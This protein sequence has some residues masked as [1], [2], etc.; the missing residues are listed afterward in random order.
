[1]NP[2]IVTAIGLMILFS[3]MKIEKGYVT[4]LL[5]HIA[6]CTHM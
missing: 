5:A 1:M 4:M 3:S 6:F 2:D